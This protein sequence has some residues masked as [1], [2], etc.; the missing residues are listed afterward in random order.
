MIY[1]CITNS[2]DIPFNG[3]KVFTEKD[4][5]NVFVDPRRQSRFPKILP[6]LFMN[7]EYSLYLDGNI[8]CKVPIEKLIKE[9]LQ[10]TDIAF[11]K[12]PTRDCYF[13]EAKE[14]MRLGLDDKEVIT[15][16]MIRYHKVPR[17]SGLYQGGVI[18]RRH[19]DKVRQFNEAWWA[20]YCRGSRRD[21]LSLPIAIQ[22]TGIAVHGIEGHPFTHQYFEMVAHNK[23][24]E[25]AG[26][27]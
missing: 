13:E 22:K 18:L 19:T 10:D 5:P 26:K 14:C 27:V 6:H 1:T 15:N 4:L 3:V 25:W 21:Q 23:P 9:W 17:H 20:E 7:T 16:Q 8:A 12:H 11:F 24:S 2:K